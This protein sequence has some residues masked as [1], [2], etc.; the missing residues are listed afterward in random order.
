MHIFRIYFAVQNIVH[1]IYL[2]E[3]FKLVTLR[4]HPEQTDD[5][6]ENARL[7]TVN[8]NRIYEIIS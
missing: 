2:I 4:F 3:L 7:T 1:F 8:E 5:V 6:A